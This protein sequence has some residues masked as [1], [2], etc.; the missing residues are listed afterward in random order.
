LDY[1]VAVA[2]PRQDKRL[3]AAPP[4]SPAAAFAAD[5]L[6]ETHFNRNFRLQEIDGEWQRPR[7]VEPAAGGGGR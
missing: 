1:R 4:R 6:E 2:E 5:L 3:P 7:R